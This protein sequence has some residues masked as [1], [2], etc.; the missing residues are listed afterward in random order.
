[1]K[2]YNWFCGLFFHFGMLNALRA[3]PKD[4]LAIHMAA[5]PLYRD[6]IYDGAADPVVIYNREKKEWW[7]FYSQ[8]RAN[9]QS[10]NVA[11]C[12]GTSIG[13]AVSDDHGQSWVYKGIA[14]LEFE[15]GVNT[16]WAP[17]IIF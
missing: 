2:K 11:F 17:D 5:A 4:S 16:F 9:V 6:P 10:A 8:R 15:E 1:M 13:I 7:M 12:Y 3:Q 14:A